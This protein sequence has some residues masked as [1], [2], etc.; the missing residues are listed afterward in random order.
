MHRAAYAVANNLP[1]AAFNVSHAKIAATD[2]AGAA[3]K[4]GIQ[5]HGAMSYTW[6]VGMH[7]FMKKAWVLDKTWGDKAFHKSRVADSLFVENCLIGAGN[8]F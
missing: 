7:I 6:E 8:T 5:V 1:S 3:D 4:S 2:D